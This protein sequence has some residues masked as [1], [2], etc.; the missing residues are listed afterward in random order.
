MVIYHFPLWQKKSKILNKNEKK[1]NPLNISF[2][3]NHYICYFFFTQ[4]NKEKEISVVAQ[5]KEIVAN[6]KKQ[7]TFKIGE[8]DII[9]GN[10]NAPITIIEYASYSCSH[11][12]SF[13]KDLYKRINKNFIKTGKVKFIYRDFPLDAPSLKASQLVHCTKEL[14]KKKELIEILFSSQ[15]NWAYNEDYLQN[16]EKIAARTG[17]SKNIF[18]QC[19]KNEKLEDQILAIRLDAAQNFKINST[20][21]I[22][23]NGEKYNGS[24]KWSDFSEF[25]NNLIKE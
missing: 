8:L 9:S 12:A 3:T 5:N 2:F 13:Y 23:V 11:C 21:S 17:M 25:L 1:Y 10:E 6:E 7:E 19:V 18:N 4:K 16:L 22:I 14:K 20:P 15:A 24:R